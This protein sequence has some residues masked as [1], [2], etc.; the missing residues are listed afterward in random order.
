MKYF[1]RLVSAS[2]SILFLSGITPAADPTPLRSDSEPASRLKVELSET[3]AKSSASIAPEHIRSFVQMVPAKAGPRLANANAPVKEPAA[4]D[5]LPAVYST[6]LGVPERPQ[7]EQGARIMVAP[8][9][10]MLP[11]IPNLLPTNRRAQRQSGNPI[12]LPA[13][14]VT[15]PPVCNLEGTADLPKLPPME[16]EI[17]V[18]IAPQ[19]APLP[20][21][22][23][24]YL[25]S[26]VAPD[27]E[28]AP[29][30]LAIGT[31]ARAALK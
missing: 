2:L 15:T 25:Q 27:D 10:A 7:L 5:R 24:P 8:V 3:A 30:T 22:Q 1:K 20:F 4:A 13:A 31:P 6:A 12:I 26:A 9:A 28:D 19:P 16:R 29:A 17:T 18:E 11:R 23:A 14:P 21:D